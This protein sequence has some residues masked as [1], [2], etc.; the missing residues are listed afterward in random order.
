MRKRLSSII[1]LCLSLGLLVF[2]L[3]RVGL[4]Q[5]IETLASARWP[6]LGLALILYIAGIALRSLR[7]RALLRAKRIQVPLSRLVVLYFVGSFFNIM[8]PAGVGGDAVRAYEL[9]RYTDTLEAAIGTVLIDR[10]IG[11]LMLFVMA[12][13]VLPFGAALLPPWVAGLVIALT[14]GSL[15]GLALLFWGRPLEQAFRRLPPRLQTLIGRPVVRKLYRSFT[16]YDRHSLA[17]A[18]SVSIVFNLL[19]IAVNV[20]IGEALGAHVSLGHYVVFISLTSFLSAL[21]ISIGGLGV[22]EGSFGLFF[23]QVGVPQTV[24]VSMSLAFYLINVLSG[25]I[26]GVLYASEGARGAWQPSQKESP[27]A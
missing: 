23:G 24:A 13:L 7:W 14:V 17:V 12:A 21:P 18:V 8:L 19:L 9:S 15:A 22:R 5:A 27:S 1:K 11:L 20:L 4:E 26:G 10:A 16:G 6:L 3:A 2:V 25:L